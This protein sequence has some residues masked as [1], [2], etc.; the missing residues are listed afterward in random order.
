MP[1]EKKQP[2]SKKR[3]APAESTEK[4]A[5]K[6][7]A[8]AE[9]SG[10]LKPRFTNFVAA[11]AIRDHVLKVP[12]NLPKYDKTKELDAM[13]QQ[14]LTFGQ[15]VNDSAALSEQWPQLYPLLQL[16][17]EYFCKE[18]DLA[19]ETRGVI[20]DVHDWLVKLKAMGLFDRE[21]SLVEKP[22]P[23]S[24]AGPM[25]LYEIVSVAAKAQT[26]M[27]KP[28]RALFQPT[29]K[30]FKLFPERDGLSEEDYKKTLRADPTSQSLLYSSLVLFEQAKKRGTCI[31]EADSVA[32][33]AEPEAEDEFIF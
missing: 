23:T 25:C 28:V 31:H 20:E 33:A 10:A 26:N 13:L 21:I 29:G 3:A 8:P 5:K 14:R 6:A 18:H 2:E 9:S 17:F 30:L 32:P 7:S 1:S 19:V 27:S 24:L 11:S 22:A 4:P 16:W 12:A 15:L